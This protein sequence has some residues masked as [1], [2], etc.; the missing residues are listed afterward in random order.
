MDIDV[1]RRLGRGGQF[2]NS[3]DVVDIGV[4]HE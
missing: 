4:S 1:M 2:D 3:W